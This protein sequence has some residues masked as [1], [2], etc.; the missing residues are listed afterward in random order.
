MC[1]LAFEFYLVKPETV[2]EPPQKIPC[3]FKEG[4]REQCGY[5][6]TKKAKVN[7]SIQCEFMP[8]LFFGVSVELCCSDRLH[9]FVFEEASVHA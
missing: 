8:R 1:G 9:S 5:S 2:N 3:C 6:G 4:F 7:P